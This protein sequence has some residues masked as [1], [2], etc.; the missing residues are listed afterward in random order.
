MRRS[1]S[2]TAAAAAIYSSCMRGCSAAGFV[3]T[4]TTTNVGGARASSNLVSSNTALNYDPITRLPLPKPQLLLE[5]DCFHLD[6]NGVGRTAYYDKSSGMF[7]EEQYHIETARKLYL[8]RHCGSRETSTCKHGVKEKEIVLG[9]SLFGCKVQEIDQNA[10]HHNMFQGAGTGSVTWESSIAMSFYFLR[11]PDELKGAVLELGSGVGLGGILSFQA[12]LLGMKERNV[13]S[14]NSL[15]LTDGNTM[16]VDRCEKNV[17]EAPYLKKLGLSVRNLD[18]NFEVEK[19]DRNVYST[20]IASDVL[21]LDPD[22]LPFAKTID[23]LLSPNGCLHMFAPIHRSTLP[24]V[25][26]MLQKNFDF[27]VETSTVELDRFRLQPFR[28]DNC[29]FNDRFFS[30]KIGVSTNEA[31]P[32]ASVEKSTFLH[33]RV[34]RKRRQ[35]MSEITIP[36]S[37]DE[38]D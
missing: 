9:P 1:A 31:C 34:H 33:L 29:D 27:E 38:L 25:I 10:K 7:I 18:W 2:T 35:E 13:L 5:G 19:R 20:I 28:V 4:K 8:L 14:L 15:T 23:N 11:N 21:Y 12:S 17:Q 24:R 36:A 22:V 30:R 16:V 37:I 32:F 26:E 6:L 3:A